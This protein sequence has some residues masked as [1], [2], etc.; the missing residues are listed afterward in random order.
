MIL[1]KFQFTKS[2]IRILPIAPP[3]CRECVAMRKT[4]GC[5]P[6]FRAF[7]QASAVIGWP[8]KDL[9]YKGSQADEKM[10]GATAWGALR[11]IILML[12]G[13]G[14]ARRGPDFTSSGK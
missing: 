9:I 6:F 8:E 3:H 10:P 4:A 5:R 12:P 2:K 13:Y 1:E 7:F 14:V 11:E